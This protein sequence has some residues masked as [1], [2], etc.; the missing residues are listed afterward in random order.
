MAL[1]DAI[2]MVS[3]S[4]AGQ[5][6]ERNE[7][8]VALSPELRL[9]ILADGIGGQNAGGVA[10]K[11]ASSAILEGLKQSWTPAARTGLDRQAAMALSQS[12]LQAQARSANNAVF[13]AGQ[14]N[15]AYTDMGSTLVACLFHDDFLTVGHLGDSRLYRLRDDALEQV[16]RD[17]SLLQE[18]LDSGMISKEDAH[19]SNNK[20][21]LTRALGVNRDEEA[22]IHSYDVRKGDLFLLC[23]DGLHGMLPDEEIEMTLAALKT[24]LELAAQQLVQAANDAGGNDNVSV[25]LLR[26]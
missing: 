24:N 22:E 6:R 16:T 26:V 3:L 21:V 15:P 11:M 20:N 18:Q 25:I 14:S 17:H 23:S 7:D 8:S 2:Q 10:S 9:A 13:E 12:V 1:T 4:D 19:L 5:V